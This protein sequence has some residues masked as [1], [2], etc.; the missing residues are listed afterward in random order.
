MIR[1]KCF[2][3]VLSSPPYKCNIRYDMYYY[4]IMSLKIKYETI[5]VAIQQKATMEYH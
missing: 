3:L 2:N 1:L 5:N 4:Y